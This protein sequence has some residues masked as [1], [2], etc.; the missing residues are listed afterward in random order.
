MGSLVV[1][2]IARI[3]RDAE[4]RKSPTGTWYSFGIAAF[5]RNAKEGKQSSDF[6]EA[7]LFVKNDI[8]GYEKKLAKGTLLYIENAYLRNDQFKGQDGKEKNKIKLMVNS[9]EIL[10]AAPETKEEPKVAKTAKY[11]TTSPSDLPPPQGYQE[12]KLDSAGQ[13]YFE[14]RAKKEAIEQKKVQDTT[15]VEPEEDWPDDVPF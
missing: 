7:D 13:K 6:F 9:Y 1:N 15:E 4:A 3:T 12:T 8:P 14:D 11:N 2:G 10:T 5:R